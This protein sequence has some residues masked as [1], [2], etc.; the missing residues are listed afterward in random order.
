MRFPTLRSLGEDDYSRR[1]HVPIDAIYAYLEAKHTLELDGSDDSSL[2]RATEQAIKVK[3][4]CG[5]RAPVPLETL[6][7]GYRFG[8][9]GFRIDVPKGWPSTRNPMFAGVISR[10]V[11][12]NGGIIDDPDEINSTLTTANLHTGIASPDLIVAG[13]NNVVVPG[14][15]QTENGKF[16]ISGFYLH[17]ESDYVCYSAPG[18]GLAV[19]LCSLLSAIDWVYL[20]RM[21]WHRILGN[22]LNKLSI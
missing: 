21:P 19:G 5:R 9:S 15:Q 18:L 14:Y 10:R 17:G 3:S 12:H 13:R 8:G 4:L 22:A 2:R 1:E 11:R 7:S 6:E 16:V 20:E